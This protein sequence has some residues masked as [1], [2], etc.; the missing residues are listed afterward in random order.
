MRQK[1]CVWGG[2]NVTNMNKIDRINRAAINTFVNRIPTTVSKPLSF[3]EIFKLNCLC[4][5]HKYK[6]DNRF[7]YF[8]NKISVN[9]PNQI[10][11]TRFSVN[12]NHFFPIICKTVSQK[13]FFYSAIK[14]W[15]ELPHDIKLI[16][17]SKL[18]KKN[19]KSLLAANS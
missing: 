18:F 19:L 6:I 4:T 15:N 10:H 3:R 13:Q 16:Q 17:P 9:V 5:L 8:T 12:E 1:N 7:E 2:G 14:Y 11:L